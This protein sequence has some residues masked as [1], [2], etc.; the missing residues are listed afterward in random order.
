MRP[1]IEV[2]SCDFQGILKDIHEAME[3][4]LTQVRENPLSDYKVI[5]DNTPEDT[6]AGMLYFKY[7]DPIPYIQLTCVVTPQGVTF[8]EAKG[9]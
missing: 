4:Y 8:E 2:S 6:A 7:A 9:Q 3:S 5:C 1:K